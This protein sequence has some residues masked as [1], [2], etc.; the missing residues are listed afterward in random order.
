MA[1]NIRMVRSFAILSKKE[2]KLL[3]SK[4]KPIVVLKK[5]KPF[6]LS[7][8][9]APGLDS[10]GVMLPY[11]GLH[12][13]LLSELKEPLVMTSAN[14]PGEPMIIE[15]DMAKH[16]GVSDYHLLHMF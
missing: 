14:Y 6:P 2:E 7:E 9:L 12:H 13:L 15:N 8:E 11:T 1:L 5:K 3:M 10:I 16:L 4:E